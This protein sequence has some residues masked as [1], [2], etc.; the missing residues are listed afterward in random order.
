MAKQNPF[1]KAQRLEEWLK[2]LI[3]GGSGAGKTL[4][5]LQ[6]ACHIA[7]AIGRRGRVAVIDS[8]DGSARLYSHDSVIDEPFY[9]SCEQC[10]KGKAIPLE[11]DVIDLRDHS[12]QEYCSKMRAAV[13]FGY[14]VLVIDSASHEWCGVNGCLEQVDALK[15]D[16]RGNKTNNAWNAVTKLHNE[17]LSDLRA[18]PIHLVAT[19]RTKPG[20]GD[21]AGQEIIIQRDKDGPFEYEF[22]FWASV[23]R[24]AP[25]TLHIEKS[26][27]GHFQGEVW[28]KAGR[29]VAEQFMLWAGHLRQ[30]PAVPASSPSAV[31]GGAPETA[32]RSAPA[33]PPRDPA[34]CKHPAWSP[35]EGPGG[36]AGASC[37]E[38]GKFQADETPP[39]PKPAPK[40]K[41]AKPKP[42]PAPE[43]AHP[44]WVIPDNRNE[45][46]YCEDCGHKE[47]QT[48]PEP[49]PK[50][51]GVALR[52]DAIKADIEKLKGA[53][54]ETAEK[55][56]GKA[57][58]NAD[59]LEKLAMW[60][61]HKLPEPASA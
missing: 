18:I 24:S 21:D 17:F 19:A 10:A 58:D 5:A 51:D 36:A 12:P 50:S 47:A 26:R 57:G 13:D 60:I 34:T 40:P 35:A 1:Q 44:R 23:N 29:F 32:K 11:F 7:E 15:G 43:C 28:R 52:I 37:N 20:R 59:R 8:E 22:G 25:G 48:T 46:Q 31:G 27:S 6:V 4:T 39:E 14:A 9:C 38:C 30:A 49:A 56:L 53:D 42:K 33:L 45:P 61:T 16:G 2:F 55:F 54:K 3:S 41:A